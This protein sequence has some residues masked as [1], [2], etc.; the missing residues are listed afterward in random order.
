[1]VKEEAGIPVTPLPPCALQ[2]MVKPFS[3]G[4]GRGPSLENL[5][6][7]W[8]KCL[9]ICK[10]NRQATSLLAEDYLQM[11]Q[12]GQIKCRGRALPYDPE[13]NIKLVKDTI[14]LRL[15]RTQMHW[16][17]ENIITHDVNNDDTLNPPATREERGVRTTDATRR[18]NRAIQVK[19]SPSFFLSLI[20]LPL[21]TQK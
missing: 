21:A 7:N 15:K 16:R 1:M 19:A 12:S 4:R 10:W 14:R 17:N 20:R 8:R 11:F 2:E 13:I 3:E 18:R 5:Q 9:G 6:F